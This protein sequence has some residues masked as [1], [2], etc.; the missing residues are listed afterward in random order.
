MALRENPKGKIISY[1][2]E[3]AVATAHVGQNGKIIIEGDAQE[4]EAHGAARIEFVEADG[5]KTIF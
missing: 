5:T 2:E 4:R 3:E 1:V